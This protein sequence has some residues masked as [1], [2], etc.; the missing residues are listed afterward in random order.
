MQCTWTVLSSVASSTLQCFL[1]LSYKRHDFRGKAIDS[2]MC[3]DFRG[4]AID[5]KMCVDFLYNI[6]LKRFFSF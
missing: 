6:C 1:T 5:S 3:V 2:K 4:K